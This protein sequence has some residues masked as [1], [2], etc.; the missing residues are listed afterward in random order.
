MQLL[1]HTIA[2]FFVLVD[3]RFRVAP[4]A[5]TMSLR[6]ERGPERR[7]V[8]DLAVEGDPHVAILICH[9]LF[10]GRAHVDDGEPPVR[11]TDRAIDEQTAAIRTAMAQYIA[12]PAQ[13]VDINRAI[14]VEVSDSGKATHTFIY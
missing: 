9:R 8:V 4:G 2:V 14:R 6:L 5:I 7:V 1:H 13:A 11:Q 10:A 3:D 12:H